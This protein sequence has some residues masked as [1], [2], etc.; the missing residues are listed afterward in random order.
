IKRKIE[1]VRQTTPGPEVVAPD[2]IP[3]TVQVMRRQVKLTPEQMDRVREIMKEAQREI[4]HQREE[5]RLHSRRAMEH[6]DDAIH[7]LL[8]PEQKPLFEEFK[9]NRANNIRQRLQNGLPPR[10][11]DRPDLRRENA[12]F[13]PNRQPG[14]AQQ[15]FSLPPQPAGKE[16]P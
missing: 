16:Q 2:W 12:P 6:A 13:G 4:V 10:P 7:Q 14:N 11:A 9:R 3:Q 15:P 1:V 5:F 8:T